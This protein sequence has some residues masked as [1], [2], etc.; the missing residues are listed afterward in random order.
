MMWKIFHAVV[1][2]TFVYDLVVELF[3][4]II[5]IKFK[6]GVD[7][8]LLKQ[9][10]TLGCAYDYMIPWLGSFT[11]YLVPSLCYWLKCHVQYIV[12]SIYRHKELIALGRQ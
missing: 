3:I 7:A 8:I 9:H 6:V 2:G 10:A 4:V 11:S 5:F 1:F 12:H